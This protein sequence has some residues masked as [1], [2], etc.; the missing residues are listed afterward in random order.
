MFISYF[1]V[2]ILLLAVVGILYALSQFRDSRGSI[3]E[4][5]LKNKPRLLKTKNGKTLL[6]VIYIVFIFL[7]VLF[8]INYS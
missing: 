3:Y 5:I 6:Y 2:F 4:Y 8:K 1:F 7:L